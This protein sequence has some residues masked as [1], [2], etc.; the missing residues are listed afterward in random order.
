ML[1]ETLTISILFVKRN[2][3]S[4]ILHFL[5]GLLIQVLINCDLSFDMSAIFVGCVG[6]VL[7]A[8]FSWTNKLI[9]RRTSNIPT[10]FVIIPVIVVFQELA[11]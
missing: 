7:S 8:I 10:F 11:L 3:P 6:G 2:A 9:F 5:A 4:L 1:V